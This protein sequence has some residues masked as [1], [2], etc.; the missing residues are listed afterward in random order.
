MSTFRTLQ[1]VNLIHPFDLFATMNRDKLPF[2]DKI[3]NTSSDTDKV[4]NA[5]PQIPVHQTELNQQLSTATY[6]PTGHDII[7]GRG[8]GSFLHE[9]NKV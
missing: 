5:F 9:G 6:Q 3:T 4:T 7:C 2:Q 8:R 1:V